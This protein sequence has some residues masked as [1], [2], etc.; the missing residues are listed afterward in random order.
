VHR[1]IATAIDW[2]RVGIPRPTPEIDLIDLTKVALAESLETRDSTTQAITDAIKTASKAPDDAGRVTYLDHVRLD[3]G[4]FAFTPFSYLVAADDG[5]TGQPRAIPKQFWKQALTRASPDDAFSMGYLAL[6]R[7]DVATTI[8]AW[9]KAAEAGVSDAMYNLGLVYEKS[10]DPPDFNKARGWYTKAAERNVTDA[11]HNLGVLLS[12]MKPPD[13]DGARMWLTRAA[14][15]DNSN[16]M[17][18]LGILLATQLEPPDFENATFWWTK[19]ASAENAEAM[20]N[21]GMLF[22]DYLKD[23]GAAE[24]WYSNAARA[25]SRDAKAALARLDDFRD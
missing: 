19:A 4:A 2:T 24:K 10:L 5:Q 8:E 11:M 12:V 17:N 25:G 16:A 20:F 6:V 23:H 14:Q 3:D 18:N 7:S 9:T 13:L 1:V 15:N 21:I 22:D